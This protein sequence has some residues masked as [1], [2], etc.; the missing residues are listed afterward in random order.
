MRCLMHSVAYLD[1]NKCIL[2]LTALIDPAPP[3]LRL[4]FA[5]RLEHPRPPDIIARMQ[6]GIPG[7]SFASFFTH[8]FSKICGNNIK[9]CTDLLCALIEHASWASPSD[10]DFLHDLAHHTIAFELLFKI[11]RTSGDDLKE[12]GVAPDR[13]IVPILILMRVC[14]DSTNE[15]DL[16]RTWF[17]LDV[18]GALEL[19]LTQH[20]RDITRV[21]GKCSIYHPILSCQ[22]SAF[23][24]FLYV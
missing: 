16:M 13:A 3:T 19:A 8:Y 4:M 6:R 5:Y 21:Y 18:F 12:C 22:R 24:W 23:F 10:R 7:R 11:L 1:F 9:Y 14:A 2:A 20:G 17:R 15:R